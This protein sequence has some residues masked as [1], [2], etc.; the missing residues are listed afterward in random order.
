MRG[1]SLES[2]LFEDGVEFDEKSVADIIRQ[3]FSA[4]RYLHSR[5][6]IHCDLTPENILFEEMDDKF[7]IKLMNFGVARDLA[8]EDQ[9][10]TP[11]SVRGSKTA[12]LHVARA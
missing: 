9:H 12:W 11:G 4:L 5:N 2:A 1:G 10:K 3:L 6:I 8:S 7:F